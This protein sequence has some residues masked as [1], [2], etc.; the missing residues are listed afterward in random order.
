MPENTGTPPR[1]ELVDLRFR[2]GTVARGVKP[3]A[4]RWTL[5]DPRFGPAYD[6]D[7]RSWQPSKA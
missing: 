2:N 3:S 4:Y 5:N 6:F 1:A 7:I